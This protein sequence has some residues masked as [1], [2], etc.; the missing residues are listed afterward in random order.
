MLGV[1]YVIADHFAFPQYVELLE[2]FYSES[3][4]I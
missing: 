4:R 1:N 3:N 2:L